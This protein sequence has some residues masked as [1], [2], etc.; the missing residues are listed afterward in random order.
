M[1]IKYKHTLPVEKLSKLDIHRMGP[2]AI[3]LLVKLDNLKIIMASIHQ[4]KVD[5][6]I[7]N[8]DSKK[9]YKVKVHTT[10][11]PSS[12]QGLGFGLSWMM[13]EIDKKTITDDMFYCFVHLVINKDE[14]EFRFFV[15]PSKD[16]LKYVDNAYNFWLNEVDTR[17]KTN[18]VKKFLLGEKGE[19]YPAGFETLLQDD[20]ED[21]WDLLK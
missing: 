11:N 19:E 20:Y 3:S 9:L 17:D 1:K 2:E 21:N 5:L 16:V 13:G 8:T 6:V 12:N 14:L 4:K 18:S 15:V 7:T 10:K